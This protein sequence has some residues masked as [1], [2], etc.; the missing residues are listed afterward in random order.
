MPS[1]ID[2]IPHAIDKLDVLMDVLREKCP[3][4]QAQTFASLRQHTLEEV[5]EVIEAIDQE[6]WQSL[7]SELGDLL[8][9]VV[10][11]ARLASERNLFTLHD[12]AETV[13]EKMIRR[14]PH[15]FEDSKTDDLSRQWHEIKDREHKDRQS[16][17]D[18]I[19][20]LPALAYAFKQQ[21][22]AARAGF[23]WNEAKDVIA[24]MEEE[25]AEFSNEVR[26]GSNMDRLEDEFGDVLFTLVN[27]GRKLGIQAELALMRTNRKFG[28]RFR[29]M[30]TL[31]IKRNIKLEDLNLDALEAIYEEAKSIAEP[32]EKKE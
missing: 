6:D 10:F 28:K 12:V 32:T 30:E 11:Y 26:Q 24:K 20:P 9:Q 23:D 3:W 4:D 22:R 2:E 7:K 1:R 18:G 27:L 17:M 15:V 5:H 21:K 31:A 29:G 14:H 8:L 25:L 19:P 13:V 16:L